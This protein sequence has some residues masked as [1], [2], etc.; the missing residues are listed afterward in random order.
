MSGMRGVCRSE[1]LARHQ[2]AVG[3]LR[4]SVRRRGTATVLDGLRQTGCLKAR[5]PRS[6]DAHWLDAV[7]VNISGG[8]AAGDRLESA[9]VVAEGARASI[10]GQAAERFYRALPG[11]APARLRT[12]ITVGP[13]ACIEWLPQQAILFDGCAVDR[14][15]RVELAADA[16]FLGVETLVFGRAATG[17]EVRSG[18]GYDL[19]RIRRDGRLVL[20]DAMRFD[21]GISERLA[22]PAVG[23]GARAVATIIYVAPDAEASLDSVRGAVGS[24]P[25][26]AGVSA[27]DGMLLARIL[28]PHGA[29]LR[30]AVVA[31]LQAIRGGRMLPR[32]WLC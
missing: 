25:G 11:A 3:E 17:E 13:R 22:R 21:G 31:G 26:E 28:A 15:L 16:C 23:A 19:I 20:H 1:T 9:F 2:R 27:W 6:A 7:T 30:A 24:A 12:D 14:A 10:A 8:V 18:R 29:A 4:V 32:V 5:F